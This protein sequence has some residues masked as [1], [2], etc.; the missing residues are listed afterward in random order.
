MVWIRIIEPTQASG[1]LADSYRRLGA[2]PARLDHIILAHS[3]RPHTLDGH[4]ALYKSVL[5]HRAN[6]LDTALAEAIGVRVSLINGCEYCVAHHA[7]GL[8]RALAD[9]ERT[10]R[11]LAAL[12]DGSFEDVYDPGQVQALLYAE[13]LT[14]TPDHMRHEDIESLRESGWSD[15]EILEINQVAAYFAYANRTVLGLGVAIE[16]ASASIRER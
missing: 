9:E 12:K 7:H 15:G 16:E 5:H 8:E 2:P 14:R 10:R 4:M 6:T 13:R 3:E 1:E 11:W